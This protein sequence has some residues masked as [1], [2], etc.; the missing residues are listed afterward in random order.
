MHNVVSSQVTIRASLSGKPP[1]LPSSP[2]RSG[3][4]VNPESVNQQ[5]KPPVS[6]SKSKS[7]VS[8][9]SKAR[10][11][12]TSKKQDGHSSKHNLALTTLRLFTDVFHTAVR[13]AAAI[14]NLIFMKL[15]TILF[16]SRLKMCAAIHKGSN[17]IRGF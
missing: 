8:G 1:T 11:T 5:T 9:A 3:I 14:T 2:D 12:Q 6:V 7:Y 13:D 10:T 16:Y 15:K 4:I 17:L